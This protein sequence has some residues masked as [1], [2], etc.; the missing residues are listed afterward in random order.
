MSKLKD[1][2]I[3]LKRLADQGVGG[4]ADNALRMFNNLCSKYKILPE[5]IST[6]NLIRKE[7]HFPSAYSRKILSQVICQVLDVTTYTYYKI[8][9]SRNYFELEATNNQHNKINE[10]YS[11][12][13]IELQKELDRTVSAFIQTNNIYSS[14]SSDKE[15]TEE[16]YQEYLLICARSK[17]INSVNPSKLLEMSN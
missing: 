6:D 8:S 15:M 7:Y 17:S 3:K 11:H 1:K 2:L 9:R 10:L 12:Y 13:M 16:E 5:S 14:H 4:E